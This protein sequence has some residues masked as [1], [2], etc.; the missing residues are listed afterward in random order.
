M[1]AAGSKASNKRC[2]KLH[3]LN[4]EHLIKV[5][6]MIELYLDTFILNAFVSNHL[7]QSP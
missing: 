2:R 4:V 6:D 3:Y 7:L 5:I 1:Q